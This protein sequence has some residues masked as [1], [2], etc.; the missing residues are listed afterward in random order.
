MSGRMMF[1]D[2]QYAE[3]LKLGDI[4]I[5]TLR[6]GRE[7]VVTGKKVV[8]KYDAIGFPM[9]RVWLLSKKPFIRKIQIWLAKN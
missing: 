3:R 8:Y 6:H 9:R 1:R 5:G 7:Y 4:V 2:W